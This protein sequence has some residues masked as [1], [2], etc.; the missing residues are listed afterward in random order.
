MAQRARNFAIATLM[1]KTCQTWSNRVC[2][3][4]DIV[5]LPHNAPPKKA[6][7]QNKVYRRGSYHPTNVISLDNEQIS[8]NYILD[9]LGP[10]SIKRKCVIAI[11][12]SH[13]PFSLFRFNVD[14]TSHDINLESPINEISNN[15]LEE[16]L[17][18]YNSNCQSNSYTNPNSIVSEVV[19]E[20]SSVDSFSWITTIMLIFSLN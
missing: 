7:V 3:A 16:L 18:L 12:F 17:L 2:L 15:Y 19:Q 4:F 8:I 13:L 6:K 10:F 9:R 5:I 14:G 11:R 1:K 20:N